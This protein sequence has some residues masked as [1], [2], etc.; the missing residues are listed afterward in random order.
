MRSSCD[1]DLERRLRPLRGRLGAARLLLQ[2]FDDTQSESY[3]L[4]SET[5]KVA[6]ASLVQGLAP[7]EAEET[8]TLASMIISVP[9]VEADR[10]ELLK[11]LTTSQQ[12]AARVAKSKPRGSQ[13]CPWLEDA[14][15]SSEWEVLLSTDIPSSAKKSLVLKRCQKL[16]L[17][18][19]AE[20]LTKKIT[21]L[22]LCAS[23]P[24]SE[25]VKLP[26][27][28]KETFFQEVKKDFDLMQRK[29]PQP[30]QYL[31]QYPPTAEEFRAQFPSQYTEAYPDN[32]GDPPVRCRLTTGLLA[33]F[34]CTYKCR[35]NK[36]LVPP[37][38]QG[39]LGSAASSQNNQMMEIMQ[40]TQQM[41]M[42]GFRMMQ[43]LGPPQQDDGV[44]LSFVGGN[45][46]GTRQ[47]RALQAMADTMVE[48]RLQRARS[49]SLAA[50]AHEETNIET[51]G[52]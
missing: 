19:P 16:G 29:A 45:S 28:T 14:F 17:R 35:N 5:Q 41:M 10:A 18:C 22:W 21:S 51:I 3:K 34:D 23:E 37:P 48:G 6:V 36:A 12:P 25:L 1:Q 44:A 30:A 8:A 7:L 33:D 24:V 27:Q 43:G 32:E 49:R 50:T 15:T 38:N 40:Q 52:F 20:P 11:G 2:G 31:R 4:A 26:L 13:N 46:A 39:I 42:M 47:P 9:W